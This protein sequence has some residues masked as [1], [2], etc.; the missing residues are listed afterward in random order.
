M[1]WAQGSYLISKPEP[2]FTNN[3]LKVKYDI[4]G[5]GRNEFVDI[6]LFVI[7]SK[8]DTLKP[9][10]ITGDIGNMI[11]CGFGKTIEWNLEKDKI[12]LDEDVSVIVKGVKSAPVTSNS[13]PAGPKKLTRGNVMA[14]SI[15]V[16]G[17]GQ[18]KASGKSAHL[19]FSGVVYGTAASSVFLNLRSK[20]LFKDYEAASGTERDRLYDQSVKNFDM[21]RYLLFGAAGAWVTNLIWSAVI[22]IK[23]N[24]LKKMDIRL[25]SNQQNKILLSAKWTF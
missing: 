20:Q 17:L 10:Y 7:N 4:T 11:S 13:G 6:T 22:P 23:E 12:N 3:I 15:F 5:C 19:I 14:S 24:P 16:P 2:T 18:K 21:S 25:T 9:R 1:V 8:G